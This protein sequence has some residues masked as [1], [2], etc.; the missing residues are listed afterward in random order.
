M[1]RPK[2]SQSVES[3]LTST[4]R[5]APE[6]EI[7]KSNDGVS[8][9]ML[10]MMQLIEKL[11]KK[12]EQ[13]ES[14]EQNSDSTNEPQVAL[15]PVVK[16]SDFEE[17]EEE[18]IDISP[19]TYIKVISL[20]PYQMNLNTRK[21]GQGKTFTFKGFGEVKRILYKDLV[22]ILEVYRHFLEKGLFYIL[23]RKVIRKNGL[24]EIY[25]GILNKETIE[26][27][28]HGTDKDTMISLIKSANE[29]QKE[30]I[31]HMLIDR[32]IAGEEIDYNLV[33]KITRASGIDI[34]KKYEE[35][36]AMIELLEES[37]K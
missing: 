36:K 35:S 8:T 21:R 34:N 1:A 13:L 2:K 12:V 4:S 6:V 33:D 30:I 19:D 10:G 14:K 17:D 5:E 29:S 31:V 26:S 11:M 20:C 22:D 15:K 16:Y 27:I 7:N 24:D 9:E 23:S 28:V 3:N 37:K 32:M 25:T 18:Q